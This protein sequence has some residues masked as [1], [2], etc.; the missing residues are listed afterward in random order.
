[1]VQRYFQVSDVSGILHTGSE[2][3]PLVIEF[4]VSLD[5]TGPPKLH[6]SNFPRTGGFFQ[7]RES[8][9][10]VLKRDWGSSVAYG[11][12][13]ETLQWLFTHDHILIVVKDLGANVPSNHAVGL[14]KKSR[15]VATRLVALDDWCS[16]VPQT[17][18]ERT[19]REI[20]KTCSSVFSQH[21]NCC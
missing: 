14:A 5:S 10:P 19:A 1:V 13:N 8:E 11:F 17:L 4:L 6:H 3:F 18:S 21:D 7:S 2:L 16:P 20:E 9:Y 15:L 12:N